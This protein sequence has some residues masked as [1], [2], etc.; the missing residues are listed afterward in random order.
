MDRNQKEEFVLSL[1]QSLESSSL[2]VVAKPLGLTVSEVT[3]LRDK[4]RDAGV[5]YKVAKNSLAR[6][7]VKGT[8]Y[9]SLTDL[10]MF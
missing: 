8:A 3:A 10:L 9:E 5:S 4:M 2:V 1:R 7:A 6:L